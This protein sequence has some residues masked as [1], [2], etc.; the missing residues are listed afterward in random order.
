MARLA[1]AVGPGGGGD[2]P[3]PSGK[4]C[5]AVR[6]PSAGNRPIYGRGG[7]QLRALDYRG[8][9]D[10]PDLGRRERQGESRRQ[11]DERRPDHR[12]IACVRHLEARGAPECARHGEGARGLG[13]R[14]SRMPRGRRGVGRPAAM[15]MFPALNAIFSQNLNRSAQSG[16]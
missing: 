10:V 8:G 1:V 7:L 3:V 15:A 5:G 2:S 16:E 13:R 4:C 9:R 6:P 11:T 14:A 12:S